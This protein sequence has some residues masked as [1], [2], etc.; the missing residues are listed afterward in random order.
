VAKVLERDLKSA[1]FESARKFVRELC[2]LDTI[3]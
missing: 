3:D 2:S 1:D